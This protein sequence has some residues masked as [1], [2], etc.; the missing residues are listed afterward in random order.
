VDPRLGDGL[1][2]P[3]ISYDLNDQTTIWMGLD[4]FYG[5]DGGL[6]GQFDENDRVVLGLEWTF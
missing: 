2:R 4:L 6:F 1:V 5:G 3:K